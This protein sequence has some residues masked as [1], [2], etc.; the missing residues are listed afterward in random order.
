MPAAL[1][2]AMKLSDGGG[3]AE[4][5]IV[6]VSFLVLPA[7]VAAGWLG[8]R[9]GESGVTWERIVVGLAVLSSLVVISLALLLG[10]R[11]GLLGSLDVWMVLLCAPT[12]V[13]SRLA[14]W[15]SLQSERRA[16]VDLEE[17]A[18]FVGK[19]CY[20]CGGRISGLGPARGLSSGQFV[21]G[22]C[23]RREWSFCVGVR[24][25]WAVLAAGLV[26]LAGHEW[27]PTM[28]AGIGASV[29]RPSVA[30]AFLWGWTDARVR[31]EGATKVNLHMCFGGVALLV[32]IVEMLWFDVTG[33]LSAAAADGV[34][35]AF[36][37]LFGTSARALLWSY[38]V[39]YVSGVVLCSA[40]VRVDELTRLLDW[41]WR[42]RNDGAM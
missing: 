15:V 9:D 10:R 34:D 33:R 5:A 19:R 17:A 4:V 30:L 22:P 36:A 8:W 7:V 26:C 42:S 40:R 37:D 27:L 29:C 25:G 31:G 32:V 35:I 1:V 18:A 23:D 16:Q 20:L 41:W 2:M 24:P 6:G 14:G 28:V 12:Y 38:A 21:H 3:L 11:W 39:A 13:L